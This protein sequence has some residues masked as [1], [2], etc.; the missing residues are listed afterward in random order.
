MSDELRWKYPVV[1]T[2]LPE[3]GMDFELVPDADA[4]EALA[5]HANVIAVPKLA[6]QLHVTPDGRGGATVEGLLR[7]AVTQNC[8]VTLES[9]DNPIEETISLRFAP[10]EMIEPVPEGLVDIG[11]A[12]PPDPLVNGTLDLAA[13][14]GEFLA[15]AVDPYPRKPGAV[16]EPPAE[17]AGRDSPF[18]ALEQLKGRVSDKKG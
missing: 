16:F 1:V 18:A 11:A 17:A 9:F 5:Q 10:P 6:A 4:R 7:A 8:V 15:L 2:D 3:A 13:V 12:D 14:I